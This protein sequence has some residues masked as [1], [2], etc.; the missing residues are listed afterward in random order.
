MITTLDDYLKFIRKN[1]QKFQRPDDDKM[2]NLLS[3]S[4][5]VGRLQSSYSNKF[6]GFTKS[7]RHVLELELGDLLYAVLYHLDVEE[8]T[9]DEIVKSNIVKLRSGGAR[10]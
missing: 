6:T 4:S 7:N 9:I 8:F 2:H 1:R 5:A 3:M 10:E